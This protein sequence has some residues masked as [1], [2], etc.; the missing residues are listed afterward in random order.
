MFLQNFCAPA[1]LKK[2]VLSPSISLSL[3]LSISPSLSL[4]LQLSLITQDPSQRLSTVDRDHYSKDMGI[5]YAAFKNEAP[6]DIWTQLVQVLERGLGS[7]QST[8]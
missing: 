4:S 6:Q 2:H 7:S 1:L 5:L 3:S 8:P